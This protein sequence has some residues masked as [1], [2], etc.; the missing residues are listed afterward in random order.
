MR[1]FTKAWWG[2]PLLALAAC[3]TTDAVPDIESFGNSVSKIINVDASAP[4]R[5]TLDQRVADAKRADFAAKKVL[6]TLSDEVACAYN[7][8][9]TSAATFS[10]SCQLVPKVFDSASGTQKTVASAYDTL[11]Q[12]AAAEEVIEAGDQS[13]LQELLGVR[14][15][16][17]L[18]AY[19]NALAALA[20][21]TAPLD[22]ANAAGEAYDAIATLDDSTARAETATNSGSAARRA[23]NRT[24]LTTLTNEVLEA[25]R[26]RLL[27]QIVSDSD[28]TIVAG[29]TQLAILTY[30][31]E[32]ASLKPVKD[33]FE[34]ALL[35]QEP[36]SV[37]GLKEAE[38]SYAALDTADARASFGRYR[39]IAAAHQAILA[40]LEAPMDLEQL[41]A[42]NKRIVALSNAIRAVD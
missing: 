30:L 29:A 32:K 35:D 11:A 15:R 25:W 14:L 31:G 10:E 20:K 17:D 7:A 2:A 33:A 18:L 12:Q 41:A 26:Y 28:S 38:D 42:A 34:T 9:A 8:P 27:R 6:Y 19:A 4:G 5:S 21:S 3:S 23:A 22:I 39:E 40:A 24:L 16:D 37:S 36:G 1:L 13:L